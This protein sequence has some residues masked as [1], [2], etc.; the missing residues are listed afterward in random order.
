MS[1]S[2]FKL[3]DSSVWIEYL[4]NNKFADLIDASQVLLL[5]T[6]SLFEIEKKLKKENIDPSK[7]KRCMEFLRLKSLIV[8]VHEEIAEKAVR[9]SLE[10]DLAAIDALI[11]AT[12]VVSNAELFTCDNDFRGLPRVKVL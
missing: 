7:I 6:L 12:A 4:F 1:V 2:D 8:P 10:H 3:I 5:S 9:I 11:Y